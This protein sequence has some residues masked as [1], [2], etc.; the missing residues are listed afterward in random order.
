MRRSGLAPHPEQSKLRGV[1]RVAVAVFAFMVLAISHATRHNAAFAQERSASDFA[2]A[3]EF[4]NQGIELRRKGDLVGALE[5]LKAAHALGNTPITGVELGKTHVQLG[6]LV[7]AEEVFLSV[8]RIRVRREETARSEGARRESA[9]LAE[10]VRARIPTLTVRITGVPLD[11]V[12][13]EIDG[14]VVLKEALAGPRL[15]DPGRHHIFAKSTSGGTAETTVDVAEGEAR[16]VELKIVFTGGNPA[17]PP[18]PASASVPSTEARIAPAAQTATPM[19]PA[20]GESS[21]SSHLLE[22]SLIGAGAAVAAVGVVLMVV[23]AGKS[24]DANNNH[25]KSAYDSAITA[26]G[27][28]LG[29]AILGAATAA[30]GGILLAV[31]KGH[32]GAHASRGFLWV[33]AGVGTLRIGGTF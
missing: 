30:T 14:A 20:E 5:K 27:V 22:W 6:Q 28:G 2:Q 25:D 10:Q 12:A 24:T 16:D 29:G 33:G 17:P 18:E 4:L 15:V 32:E 13:V 19:A 7:E 3:R 21:S 11:S 26:W 31:S 8:A 1:S 9:T 23:E